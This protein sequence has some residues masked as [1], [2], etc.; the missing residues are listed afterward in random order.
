MTPW[1]P[2][3]R[4]AALVRV[5]VSRVVDTQL[6]GKLLDLYHAAFEP[7]EV[8]SPARQSF[9]DEE[10]LAQL[11][12]EKVVKF[13]A[14]DGGE[15]CGLGLLATDL[16]EVPWISPRYFE[17]RLPDYYTRGLIHYVTVIFVAEGHRTSP[18]ASRLMRAIARHA[19]KNRAYLVFDF[20]GANVEQG[21]GLP[22]LI[23]LTV[24]R[25]CT[26]VE[27]SELDRQSYYGLALEGER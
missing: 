14:L 25:I 24:R 8:A 23:D 22:R 18:S 11:A 15:P 3:Y 1:P 19:A 4:E 27:W 16:H 2:G 20:C 12:S 10:F 7:L 26:R 21:G 13:V 17:A 6:A 5:D 9:T